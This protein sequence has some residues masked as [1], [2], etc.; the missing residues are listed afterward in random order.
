M[1]KIKEPEVI[2]K[3]YSGNPE[4]L[5]EQ[6]RGF[7]KDIKNYNC[8]TRAVIVPHAG[9][10]YS[11]LPAYNGIKLLD[12]NIKNIFIFAPAHRVFF[13]GFSLTTFDEW[14]TPFGNIK[15]NQEINKE[16]ESKFNVKFFDDGIK[17]NTR[18]RC[19]FR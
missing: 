11:G 7:D 9:L 2:N 10:I 1:T 13:E 14:K 3:F 17:T 8:T 12:K 19:K 4:A 5:K 15:V 18:L 16:L 6:I